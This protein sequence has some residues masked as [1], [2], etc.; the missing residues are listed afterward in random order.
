MGRL[1]SESMQTGKVEK[2]EEGIVGKVEQMGNAARKPEGA[3]V[4]KMVRTKGD[5]A[6]GK[7]EN[8][9]VGKLAENTETGKMVGKLEG[10]VGKAIGK[11]E[12]EAAVGKVVKDSH[13]FAGKDETGDVGKASQ[14]NLG[15]EVGKA[16]D[17]QNDDVGKSSNDKQGK[18]FDLEGF[19]NAF[20][21]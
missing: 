17:I 4:D 18:G 21:L 6:V 16:G 20:L 14:K 12:S 8:E 5:K 3:G 15:S 11:S 19:V 10:D 9:S 1:K 7:V 13:T 2:I